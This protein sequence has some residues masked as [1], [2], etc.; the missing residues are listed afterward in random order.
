MTETEKALLEFK[1]E[2]RNRAIDEFAEVIKSKADKE[3]MYDLCSDEDNASFIAEIEEIAEH[4]KGSET[5]GK[6]D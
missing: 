4:M 2:I 1:K 5:D 3:W 6:I